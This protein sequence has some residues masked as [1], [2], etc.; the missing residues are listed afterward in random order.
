MFFWMTNVKHIVKYCVWSEVF[1][2]SMHENQKLKY[3]YHAG[4]VTRHAAD[5]RARGV[6]PY[7]TFF[8]AGSD[9]TRIDCCVA[10]ELA[11][12]SCTIHVVSSQGLAPIPSNLRLVGK[13]LV[14][15]LVTLLPKTSLFINTNW[16][17]H[18]AYQ[19]RFPRASKKAPQAGPRT[20]QR[21]PR[22]PQT[23]SSNRPPL[24][25]GMRDSFFLW[26]IVISRKRESPSWLQ[27]GDWCSHNIE[28]K[29]HILA[30]HWAVLQKLQHSII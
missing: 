11:A 17:Y 19:K 12:R 15:W 5:A 13:V 4:F 26:N 10:S 7:P 16:Q 9:G 6:E 27:S 24:C 30:V 20:P 23:P 14:G 28:Q 1:K 25:S 3:A 18:N 29:Q 2:T 22:G 8:R 21:S